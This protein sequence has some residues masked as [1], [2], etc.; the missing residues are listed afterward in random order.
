MKTHYKQL[1]LALCCAWL[2]SACTYHN[3]EDYFKTDENTCQTENIS[4]AKDIQ[5]LLNEN[6]ISCHSASFPMGNI[7]LSD[8][9]NVA[10]A[11]KGGKLVSV[12]KHQTGYPA[13]PQGQP[14][15]DDCT[16][17][18]IEAWVNDGFKNN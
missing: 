5:P 17:A 4:F 3:E 15:L 8:Y 14:K 10:Q 6:C 13:M 16:I 9:A 11:A 18:K 12:I 7:D 2:L 1:L